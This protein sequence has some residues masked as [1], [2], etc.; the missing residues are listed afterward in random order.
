[1]EPLNWG[2]G[3][4]ALVALAFGGLQIWWIGS[5]L[6]KRD[7]ARPMSNGEFLKSLERIWS[8]EPPPSD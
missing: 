4:L 6:R 5:I 7:L 3:Q 8:K 1:M 2:Y